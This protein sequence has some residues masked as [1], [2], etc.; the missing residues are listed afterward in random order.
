MIVVY[1]GVLVARRS[2]RR[3]VSPDANVSAEH[4]FLVM[5]AHVQLTTVCVAV[6]IFSARRRMTPLLLSQFCLSVC[7]SHSSLLHLLFVAITYG[8][9]TFLALEKSGKLMEFIFS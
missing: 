2:S 4:R 9:V 3:S 7:L 8:K 5:E 1:H 6:N